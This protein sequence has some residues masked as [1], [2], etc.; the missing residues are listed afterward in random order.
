MG[1]IGFGGY[2]CNVL[3]GLLCLLRRCRGLCRGRCG[4]VLMYLMYVSMYGN[5]TYRLRIHLSTRVRILEYHSNRHQHQ[6]QKRKREDVIKRGC[7][8]ERK[9]KEE[10]G[11]VEI[12][13]KPN[14]KHYPHN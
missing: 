1:G 13:S 10:K 7:G 14:T 9:G 12:P 4:V 11:T 3:L 8:K 2:L 6:H 5:I